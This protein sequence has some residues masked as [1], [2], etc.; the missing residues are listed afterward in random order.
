MGRGESKKVVNQGTAQSAQDQQNAQNALGA[1]NKAVSDYEG[2]LKN[3]LRFG[4][5]TYGEGG[6][7]MRDQNTLA[8]TTAKGQADQVAGNLA[9]H[10]M[11]TGENTAGYASTTAE[12]RRAASRDLTG[13]LAGADA[14]R[15]KQLTAINQYGV[16]AQKFPA[17]VQE[18]LYGTSLSGSGG[19]LSAASGAARTPGFWDEFA[20]ALAGAAGQVGKGFTPNG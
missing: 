13:Q 14:E 18:S 12:A 16:E 2:A 4:R 11:A 6:E 7:F 8:T 3:F 10:A 19:Q 9:L 20:P 5:S 1:T 17:A 15:L